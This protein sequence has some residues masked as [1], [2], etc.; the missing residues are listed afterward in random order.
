MVPGGHAH[1]DGELW[2]LLLIKVQLHAV[3]EA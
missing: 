1:A 3:E 2:G